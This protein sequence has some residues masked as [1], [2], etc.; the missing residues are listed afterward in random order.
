MLPAYLVAALSFGVVM[1]VM[2]LLASMLQGVSV[3][4]LRAA[5]RAEPPVDPATEVDEETLAA[6]SAAAHAAL[7]APVR[8]HH[9]HLRRAS[10]QE[11]WS[12]AGRM[13]IMLSH[14]VSPNR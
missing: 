14:R 7:G 6:L 11:R 3:I 8:I 2:A 4:L 1:L 10:E 13:D 9:V 5:R 12:R